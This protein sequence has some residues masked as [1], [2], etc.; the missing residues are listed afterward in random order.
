MHL[1]SNLFFRSL[2]PPP[3]TPELAPLRPASSFLKS[4]ASTP[5]LRGE[6]QGGARRSGAFLSISS[7]VT[8]RL[9]MYLI[10]GQEQRNGL[11][12]EEWPN[13]IVLFS[14]VLFFRCAFF[15]LCFF[16]VVLYSRQRL[17]SALC[18]S[19]LGMLWKRTPAAQLKATLSLVC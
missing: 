18:H 11:G 8:H 16:S 19:L 13:S 9:V 4:F 10:P 12:N 3:E 5:R 14:V 6:A 2:R 1:S 7:R 15:P 17:Y